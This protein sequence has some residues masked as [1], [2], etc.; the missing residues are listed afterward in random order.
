MTYRIE[1]TFVN[2][3]TRFLLVLLL[4]SVGDLELLFVVFSLCSKSSGLCIRDKINK[5]IE[6]YI[7]KLHPILAESNAQ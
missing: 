3:A 4:K 5:Y 6:V 2:P 7:E 1:F